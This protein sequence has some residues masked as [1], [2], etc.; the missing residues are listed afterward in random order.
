[1]YGNF[2][3]KMEKFTR[4]DTKVIK[5]IAVILMFMHHLWAFPD[6]IASDMQFRSSGIMV[7]GTDLFYAAGVFGQIC[8][9]V[10]MFL[11]G[12]GLWQ[13]MQKEYSLGKDLCRLYGML[14]KTAVIFIP[15][16]LLF[17]SHQTDYAA[18]T[19]ICHVFE[20]RSAGTIL[21]NFL[22]LAVSYNREWWFFL[23]FLSAMIMGYV[24]ICKNKINQFWTDAVIVALIEIVSQRLLPAVCEIPAFSQLRNDFFFRQLFVFDRSVCVF[25]L[26][27]VFA[28]YNAID[29]LREFYRET[30]RSKTGR[31]LAAFPGMGVLFWCRTF[32][33]GADFD[34]FYVPLFILFALEMAHAA[35][36]LE[37]I[38]LVFGMHSAN[39]WLIHGFYCYYFY[40]AVKIV[41]W[42]GSAVA[43]LIT[44]LVLTIASSAA[45]NKLYGAVYSIC[46]K[47]RC[48]L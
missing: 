26:G 19:V 23:P 7:H 47:Y 48:I 10:F 42:S 40:A 43:A 8:V 39:M 33:Y 6:R 36:F 37:K 45:M 5:G 24:F 11:G 2:D 1:M 44:L 3:K 4:N 31:V 28:K 21:N 22:G 35:K 32:L 18:D 17:F 20:D 30:F 34:L 46:K 15:V 16:G 41:C 38:L 29:R 25:F 9:P 13:K 14:W 27:I 12:Y